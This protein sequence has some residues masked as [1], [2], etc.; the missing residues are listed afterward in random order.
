MPGRRDDRATGS[1]PARLWRDPLATVRRGDSLPQP[2]DL[3]PIREG[4]PRRSDKDAANKVLFIFDYASPENTPEAAEN[5]RRE[6]YAVLSALNMAGYAA[7]DPDHLHYVDLAPLPDPAP[8]AKDSKPGESGMRVPYEWA[9]WVRDKPPDEKAYR[10]DCVLWV[11]PPPERQLLQL[12]AELKERQSQWEQGSVC[13]FAITGRIDSSRLRA[14]LDACARCRNLSPRARLSSWCTGAWSS[15]PRMSIVV[16]G[17]RFHIK[18]VSPLP[19]YCSAAGG[20][21]PCREL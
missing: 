9:N 5:R 20:E 7:T 13:W 12:L 15:A 3:A 2:R 6:R 10:A 1:V 21:R 19:R 14:M 8:A 11:S 18:W 4:V 16:K 17:F